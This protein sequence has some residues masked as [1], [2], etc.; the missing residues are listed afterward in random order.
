MTNLRKAAEESGTYLA[1][2]QGLQDGVAV[3]QLADWKWPP[4]TIGT[5]R[6]LHELAQGFVEICGEYTPEE[7]AKAISR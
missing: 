3:H 5:I 1:Y 6:A 4:L 2:F 7:I